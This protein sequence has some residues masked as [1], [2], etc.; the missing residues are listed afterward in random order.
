MS[1]TTVDQLIKVSDTVLVFASQYM[2]VNLLILNHQ[3]CSVCF[4]LAQMK[5]RFALAPVMN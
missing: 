1:N 3:Q 2:N 5:L 4:F